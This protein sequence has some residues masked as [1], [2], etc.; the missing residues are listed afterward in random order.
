MEEYPRRRWK[1]LTARRSGRFAATADPKAELERAIGEANDR[2][3]RLK[4]QAAS[5]IANHKLTEARLDRAIE[6]LERV[7]A[8]ARR[9]V[10]MAE[11]EGLISLHLQASEAADQAKA[12][13]AQSSAALRQRLGER[14]K[15][16]GQ[17]D[18]AKMQQRVDEAMETLSEGIG[19]DVPSFD[20][21]RERI[22]ARY[23]KAKASAD[24]V[25]GEQPA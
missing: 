25:E 24:L 16:L 21:V 17:L 20:E 18:Q 10:L 3:R 6:E 15:L 5:V 9:A 8:D 23:A 7:N 19:H 1:Y 14:Q 11:I 22:E 13:V 2:H 4:D 12:A